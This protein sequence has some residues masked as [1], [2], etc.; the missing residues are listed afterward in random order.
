MPKRNEVERWLAAYDNPM[1]DVVLAIRDVILSTDPR[2]DECIKWQAPTF[3]FEGNIASFYPKSKQHA[4]LMFHQGARIPGKHPR[5]QGAGGTSRILKLGSVGEVEQAKRELRAIVAAWIAWK[6]G[7]ASSKAGSA[8]PA[9]KKPAR[10]VATTAK[11]KKRAA[12]KK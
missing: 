11:P 4:S 12:R 8:P 5:L 10:K 1:K 9:V 3:T 6:E 7:G 2:V